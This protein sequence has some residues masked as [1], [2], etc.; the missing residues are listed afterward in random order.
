M[1]NLRVSL[2]EKGEQEDSKEKDNRGFNPKHLKANIVF[3]NLQRF[4]TKGER[5][6]WLRQRGIKL[7]RCFKYRDCTHASLKYTYRNSSFIPLNMLDFKL[8]LPTPAFLISWASAKMWHNINHKKWV[9]LIEKKQD[10]T[11]L[12]SQDKANKNSFWNSQ[13]NSVREKLYRRY[14]KYMISHVCFK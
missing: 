6:W 13:R 11:N 1:K 7:W 3:R 4:S 10:W 8:A 12:S 5:N 9:L 2:W 14:N